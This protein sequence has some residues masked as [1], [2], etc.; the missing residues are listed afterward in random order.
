LSAVRDSCNS[1]GKA[2]ILQFSELN[3]TIIN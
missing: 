1:Y 2:R 3:E